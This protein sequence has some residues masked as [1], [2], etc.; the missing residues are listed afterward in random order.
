MEVYVER[1]EKTLKMKF[2]GTVK[3]LLDKLGINPEDAMVV[4]DEDILTADDLVFN[5][6]TIRVLSVISG[7]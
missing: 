2:K 1:M 7:G 6:D 4:R 3:G 5:T